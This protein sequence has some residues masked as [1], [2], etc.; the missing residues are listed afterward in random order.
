MS[1]KPKISRTGT[2]IGVVILGILAIIG[3]FLFNRQFHFNPAVTALE[4]VAN[5]QGGIEPVPK[6][7]LK[8]LPPGLMI[9][10]PPE[11]FDTDTLYEKIDGQAELYLAAG[12][13]GLKSQRFALSG[14]PEAWLEVYVYD[15]GDPRNAFAVF[16]SQRREDAQPV[17]IGQFA[18]RTQN[19]FFMAQGLKYGLLVFI[20][21]A[22]AG[23]LI[24]WGLRASNQNRYFGG[25]LLVAVLAGVGLAAA[26]KISDRYAK[27]GLVVAGTAAVWI[28]LGILIRDRGLLAASLQSGLLDPLCLAY[29][30][31]N[32]VILPLV[33]AT[34]SGLSPAPGSYYGAWEPWRSAN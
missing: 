3:F 24:F 10:S 6:A 33:D 5:H 30:S 34:V 12:F 22:A 28:L 17:D 20:L 1:A 4:V 32:L 19:A 31:I 29:R 15:M 23:D 13:V 9:L 26:R 25:F 18:Y 27:A 11:D 8:S 2:F 21:S 14:N 16:S 7:L